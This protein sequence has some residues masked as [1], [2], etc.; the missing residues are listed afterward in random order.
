MKSLFHKFRTAWKLYRFGMFRILLNR[1]GSGIF[2]SQN[3]LF[4]SFDLNSSVPKPELKD[5]AVNFHKIISISDPLFLKFRRKFPDEEFLLR[6]KQR[7]E[8]CYLILYQDE[9]AGYGWVAHQKIFIDAV[10]R[11]YSL[12][13]EEFYIYSC[14]VEKKR[15][16]SGIYPALLRTI[17]YEYQQEETWER[18]LIGVHSENYGSIHGIEKA[19]FQFSNKV[20]YLK[21]LKYEKWRFFKDR[22]VPVS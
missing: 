7:G 17:L 20:Q 19:G 22:P 18:G 5:S 4:Y 14:Y 15:R 6:I 2:R 11:Y 16:G 8:N 3:F 12:A 10:N 1:M 21:F 13:P 9:I